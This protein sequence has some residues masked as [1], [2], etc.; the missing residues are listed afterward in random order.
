VTSAPTRQALSVLR[1]DPEVAEA[2]AAEDAD[3]LL[4]ELDGLR[5]RVL[6]GRESHA[7]RS[8]ALER[9]LRVVEL[10]ER[11]SC[12]A[13]REGESRSDLP[14]DSWVAALW[15]IEAAVPRDPSEGKAVYQDRVVRHLL[16]VYPELERPLETAPPGREESPDEA[17]PSTC[18]AAVEREEPETCGVEDLMLAGYRMALLIEESFGNCR[19]GASGQD[20]VCLPYV[21]PTPSSCWHALPLGWPPNR[22]A[23]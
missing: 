15:E 6:D 19:E 20:P 5:D 13:A 14:G 7:E 23:G 16:A 11:R 10:I 12:C 1:R 22:P 18:S 9:W 21:G 17:G 4:V 8:L 3:H 2:P